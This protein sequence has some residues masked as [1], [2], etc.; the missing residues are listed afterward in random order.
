MMFKLLEEGFNLGLGVASVAVNRVEGLVKDTLD[1]VGVKEG[2]DAKGLKERLVN[3]GIA[4]Q[5]KIKETLK[6]NTVKLADLTPNAAKLDLSL[7]KL[8]KLEAEVAALK[9]KKA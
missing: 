7:E 2:E 1:K 8:E 5:E 4:A 9:P 3:E 6:K